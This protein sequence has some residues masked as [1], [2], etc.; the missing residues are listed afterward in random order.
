MSKATITIHLTT[1]AQRAALIAGE[2]AAAKQTY[3]VPMELLPRLLALPWT[4]VHEDGSA[5]CEVPDTLAWRESELDAAPGTP[6]EYGGGS[7]GY[8]NGAADKRP[9]SAEAAIAYA[10]GVPA[11]VTADLDVH[12]AKR[13]KEREERDQRKRAAVERWLTYPEAERATVSGL[14]TC[15]WKDD[16][17]VE[18]LD[19][20]G[21]RVA[22]EDDI[23][24][25]APD[26]YRAAIDEVARLKREKKAD[27]EATAKAEKAA[28]VACEAALRELATKRDDLARAAADGYPITK[29]MLDRLAEDLAARIDATNRMFDVRGWTNM[30]DRSAPSPEAFALRDKVEAA[31]RSENE[32]LA[33]A[34][35]K[36]EVSR[37]VR[38]DV[39]PHE[40]RSHFVTAVVA[41]LDTPCGLREITFST[42]PLEC[43]HGDDDNDD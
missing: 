40:E 19:T 16:A 27:A 38:L 13:Q 28:K 1:D 35:G 37:I 9:A 7:Y 42:D 3:E 8:T 6:W 5:T 24:R 14:A 34:V 4:T 31:A 29:A 15:V 12:R 17:G 39:C 11:R 33:P 10:E 21:T 36:W 22:D 23:K 43:D 18:H 20:T 26:A 41:T 30:R 32:T 25:F 2:D